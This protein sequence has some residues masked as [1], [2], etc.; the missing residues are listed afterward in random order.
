MWGRGRECPWVH[1]AGYGCTRS[2][3]RKGPH[4][5]PFSVPEYRGICG[6]SPISYKKD[7]G[8]VWCTHTGRSRRFS[9]TLL[10]PSKS[11]QY[12]QLT[13]ADIRTYDQHKLTKTIAKTILP[14]SILF[15]QI[16]M[17]NACSCHKG[18]PKRLKCNLTK[19]IL[20]STRII[21]LTSKAR[22]T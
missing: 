6:G 4:P 17:L 16:L 12:W 9:V 19:T 10:L 11:S 5:H 22:V 15:F 21:F 1:I 7:C 13:W 8:W 3:W 2:R 14:F 18:R 20:I